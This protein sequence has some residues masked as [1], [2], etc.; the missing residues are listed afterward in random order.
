VPTVVQGPRSPHP[1]MRPA[2]AAMM[3]VVALVLLGA[4]GIAGAQAKV[5]E[6]AP[7]MT[8]DQV[9][10]RL[11]NPSEESHSGSFTYLMYDNDCGSKCR[12]NDLVVL[13]GG[14]VTDAVFR[15]GK[16]TYTGASSPPSVLQAAPAAPAARVAPA[17]IR[18]STPDDSVHRGGIVLMG[19][20]PPAR[21]SSYVRLVPNHADSVRFLPNTAKHDSVPP[22]PAP[23]E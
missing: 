15:S 10:S 3:S 17:P 4:P 5:A 16:G 12:M 6:I 19:P 23:H 11:G 2:I 22:A 9:L 1:T 20:R 14:V 21:P 8:K 13:E 7:G 18:A